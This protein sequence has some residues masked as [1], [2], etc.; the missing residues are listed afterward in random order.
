MTQEQAK[1]LF[2]KVVLAG[3]ILMCMGFGFIIGRIK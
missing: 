2:V 1:A 3:F